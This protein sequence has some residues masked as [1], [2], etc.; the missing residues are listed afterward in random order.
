MWGFLH[1]LGYLATFLFVFTSFLYL[2]EIVIIMGS[3]KIQ[4]FLKAFVKRLGKYLSE[5]I[6]LQWEK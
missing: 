1:F 4:E 6:F 2:P 5:G 3:G